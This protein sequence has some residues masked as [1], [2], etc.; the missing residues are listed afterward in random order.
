MRN[1]MRTRSVRETARDRRLLAEDAGFGAFSPTS[2]LAGMLVAYAL[3]AILLGVA[4]AIA[5]AAGATTDLSG[6]WEQLGTGAG[7]VVAGLLFVS[8]LFGGYVAGRMA[9]RRGVVH[10]LVAAILGVVVVAGVA[11]LVRA[12]AGTTTVADNLRSLGLPTTLHEYGN[13]ATVTGLAALAAIVAGSLLGGALGER[14]HGRLVARAADPTVGA[15][16]E[17]ARQAQAARVRA[18]EA[19]ARSA[20]RTRTDL[21]R[22]GDD[23]VVVPVD[24]NGHRHRGRNGH[25]DGDGE[26]DRAPAE[27]D[28]VADREVAPD[29]IVGGR[30]RA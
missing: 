15:Q 26:V 30:R 20:A 27:R 28:V 5:G 10:G 22:G 14:W 21:E 3:F 24:G 19:L 4:V 9:R 29:T 16:A 11:A 7:L 12:S 18:D 6:N 2:A 13:A 23:R 8:W 17:A 1:G 25:R